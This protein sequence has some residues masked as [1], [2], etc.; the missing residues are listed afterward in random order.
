MGKMLHK[1]ASCG[2]VGNWRFCGER[3]LLHIPC[4]A[5]ISFEEW[6]NLERVE[7]ES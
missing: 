6:T 5:K 1:C 3:E 7:K 2:G 4:G